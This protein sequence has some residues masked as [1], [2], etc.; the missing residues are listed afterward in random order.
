VAQVDV[1][2][3]GGQDA[4][5]CSV[6]FG[7]GWSIDEGRQK[8]LARW[9]VL[10]HYRRASCSQRLQQTE[11]ISCHSLENQAGNAPILRQKS[12]WLW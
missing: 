4:L 2:A 1:P 5:F 8:D 7:E 10:R 3:A 12:L 9:V 6:D 11:R